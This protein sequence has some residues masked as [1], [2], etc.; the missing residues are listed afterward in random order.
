MH[1]VDTSTAVAVMPAAEA[2]GVPGF[3]TKGDPVGGLPATVLGQDFLNMV[4]EELIAVL[5]AAGMTPDQTKV[6]LG[7]LAVAVK[8]YV[9]T[10]TAIKYAMAVENGVPTLTEV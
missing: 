1:R 10:V 5:V 2:P 4:Q 3:F 8:R 6:D 7:Q 9:D